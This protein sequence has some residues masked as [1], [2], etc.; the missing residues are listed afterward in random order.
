MKT[1]III[2]LSV[3]C[4]SLM[5]A[6]SSSQS[7]DYTAVSNVTIVNNNLTD[8]QAIESTLLKNTW[9]KSDAMLV[10]KKSGVAA[11]LSNHV[12]R[13]AWHVE[14]TNNSNLLVLKYENGKQEFFELVIRNNQLIWLDAVGGKVINVTA[15]PIQESD[16]VKQTR[17]NLVG[18]WNSSIF[19]TEVLANLSE[20]E[21]TSITSASFHYNFKED[22]TFVKTITVNQN[23]QERI[24][25]L[26]DISSDGTHLV[27]HFNNNNRSK[28]YTAKIKYFSFDEL[29]L[30]QALVTSDL[31]SRICEGVNSFFFSK[32]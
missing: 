6:N 13:A 5:F 12:G 15:E 24:E 27:M 21:K 4:C 2:L 29:V 26:W 20:Q 11:Y 25:G 31:E 28:S 3:L 18:N 19:S 1:Q 10:F 9:H 14:S 7:L 8:R 22:G 32:Q 30:D 16:A 17:R 23:V